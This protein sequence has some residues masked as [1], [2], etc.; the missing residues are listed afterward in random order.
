[1]SRYLA[2]RLI[3]LVPLLLGISL[4]SYGIIRFAPGDPT[5]LLADPERA[6][7][8]QYVAIRAELGLDDP[9]PVQFAKTMTAL[10]TGE[11]RSYRTRQKVVDMV[12]ERLPT[13]LTLGVLTILV[14]V[15]AGVAIGIAQSLRPYSRLDD[16]GTFVALIGFSVPAFW[17]ALMLQMLFA[18]RL[19]WLPVSGI[20]PPTATGWSPLEVAPYVVLPT[21]VLASGLVATVSRYVRSSML[22]A[23]SQ[24]YVRTARSKGLKNR[25]V[26]V[27]HALRNSLLPV[28]TLM[29]TFLPFLIGGA[30]IVEQIFALPGVGRL[31]ID[32]I[33]IRDYPVIISITMFSALAVVLGNLIADILYAVADPRIQYS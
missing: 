4:L 10:F 2:R 22:E 33:F 26:I 6:T 15:I 28:I 29:G 17:L 7:A 3:Q 31:A 24:D 32:A 11:L 13:T 14:G 25:V 19:H 12:A 18:V 21:I 8:E 23:L 1:M 27:R 9:I 5:L 16:L 20:R 30:V